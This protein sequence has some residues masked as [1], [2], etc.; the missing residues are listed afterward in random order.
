MRIHGL[1]MRAFGPFTDAVLDFGTP[2]PCDL[3]VIF[4]SNEAGK[5]SALRALKA[6]LFGFPDGMLGGCRQFAAVWKMNA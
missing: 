5:S 2:E 4:G 6:W 3:H 1:D